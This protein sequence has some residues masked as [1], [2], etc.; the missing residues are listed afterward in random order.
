M[1]ADAPGDKM[2]LGIGSLAVAVMEDRHIDDKAAAFEQ[3][4]Q[5]ARHAFRLHESHA[6]LRACEAD[7][8]NHASAIHSREL[9]AL[10]FINVPFEI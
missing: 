7:V 2:C 1:V 8:R 5:D 4:A 6:L 3:L 9:D 10:G